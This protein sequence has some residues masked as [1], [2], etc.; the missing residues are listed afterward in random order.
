MTIYQNSI[1]NSLLLSKLSKRKTIMYPVKIKLALFCIPLFL[2]PSFLRAQDEVETRR[3]AIEEMNRFGTDLLRTLTDSTEQET[4]GQFEVDDE[5]APVRGY[6][7]QLI[8]L[9]DLELPALETFMES[10]YDNGS[11]KEKVA[12]Q[13][14][15]ESEYRQIKNEW[16]D[17]FRFHAQY[18]YGYFYNFNSYYSDYMPANTRNAQHSWNIGGNINVSLMD[19][20]NRK[21]KLRTQKAKI[22]QAIY[23]QE[24]VVEERKLRILNAYNSILENLAAVKP[25]AETVALYNAQMKIS[26]NNFI[27]GQTSIIELSLERQR[28]STA[29]VQYQQGRVALYNAVRTLELLTNIKIIKD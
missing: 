26:E 24:A 16:W 10:V 17:Y 23:L 21:H 12:F 1:P 14:Q 3:I 28:R 9:E 18:S 6:A 22:D 8:G 25:R 5:K 29:I 27:N 13:E 11:V 20:F 15:M 2:T 4:P 19:L 7:E